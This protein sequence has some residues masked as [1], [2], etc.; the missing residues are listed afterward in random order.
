MGIVA[1]L[2]ELIRNA[3]KQKNA[4]QMD[5]CNGNFYKILSSV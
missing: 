3:E 5:S 2:W 4:T 1:V